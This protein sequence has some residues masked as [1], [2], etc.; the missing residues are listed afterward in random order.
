MFKEIRDYIIAISILGLIAFL[1]N[2]FLIAQLALLILCWFGFFG[3]EYA[4]NGGSIKRCFPEDFSLYGINGEARR[5]EFA[6]KQ[7]CPK[8]DATVCGSKRTWH[9]RDNYSEKE[10]IECG[11]DILGK[12]YYFWISKFIIPI[13]I[14]TFL[15]IK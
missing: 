4:I 6:K 8:Y 1:V 12:G 3:L 11:N 13:A 7:L 10:F 14:A 2:Q 15:I 9:S 5:A